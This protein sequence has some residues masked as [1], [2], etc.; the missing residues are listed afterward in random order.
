MC[1]CVFLP[2]LVV[3]VSSYS[4]RF[5]DS[6]LLHVSCY[7]VYGWVPAFMY[8]VL[9]PCS[10]YVLRACFIFCFG[11]FCSLCVFF[12]CSVM[13]CGSLF[14]SVCSS[15]LCSALL[16]FL[17]AYSSHHFVFCS[18]PCFSSLLFYSFLF[19]KLSFNNAWD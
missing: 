7:V 2:L 13:F 14:F 8:V 4:F 1:V 11:M 15:L 6:L 16:L 10:S 17:C 3:T 18:V 12:T 19:R 9:C 5:C